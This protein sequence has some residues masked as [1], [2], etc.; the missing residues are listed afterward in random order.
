MLPIVCP[1]CCC[2][3]ESAVSFVAVLG[4]E[5]EGAGCDIEGAGLEMDGAG[6]EIDGPVGGKLLVRAPI[7][8]CLAAT[9][10]LAASALRVPY[11]PLIICVTS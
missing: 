9:A 6:R 8:F 1:L 4:R 10:A 7:S 11:S 3:G 2:D 5:Y